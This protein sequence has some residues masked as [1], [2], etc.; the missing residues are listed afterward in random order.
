VDIEKYPNSKAV[1]NNLQEIE[2]FRLAEP[3]NQ[4]DFEK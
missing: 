2:A 1:L 3:K 4:P